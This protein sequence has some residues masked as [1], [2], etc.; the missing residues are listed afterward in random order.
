MDQFLADSN[1]R[2]LFVLAHRLPVACVRFA[3]VLEPSSVHRVCHVEYV[4]EV[5]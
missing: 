5:L 1:I 3:L 4:H 2:I